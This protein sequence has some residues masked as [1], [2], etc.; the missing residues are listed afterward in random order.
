M[1]PL[2]QQ[3]VSE[4]REQ[5]QGISE[6]LLGLEKGGDIAE[7]LNE[8]FR[9]VHTL[10]GSSGLFDFPDMTRVLH[11]GEDLLTEL[12]D[13]PDLFSHDLNDQLFDCMDFVS[14]QLDDL[15]TN[16]EP[17][18]DKERADQLETALRAMLEQITAGPAEAGSEPTSAAI[19]EVNEADR[20]AE[21][22]ADANRMLDGPDQPEPEAAETAVT[23][24]PDDSPLAD[25]P[26]LV[27]HEAVSEAI[28]G[29]D[30]KL[31]HYLPEETCFFTG[32][33]P[34]FQVMQC[35]GALW[36]TVKT[37][38]PLASVDDLDPFQ[39]QLQFWAL[40][41]A[42]AEELDD[43]FRYN[44]EALSVYS[45]APEQLMAIDQHL[46]HQPVPDDVLEQLHHAYA[47]RD[48]D[49]LMTLVTHQLEASDEDCQAH[50]AL[51]WIRLVASASPDSPLLENSWQLLAELH[52]FNGHHNTEGVSI[53]HHASTNNTL[54]NAAPLNPADFSP[55]LNEVLQTQQHILGLK[56]DSPWASG[57]V[58]AAGNS[59]LNSMGSIGQHDQQAALREHLDTA[60]EHG[61]SAPMTD[62]LE[63]LLEPA[64]I[65]A[66]R[67]ETNADTSADTSSSE[68]DN[69]AEAPL[70][71]APS[72]ETPS[73]EAKA[74][75]PAQPTG[76]TAP[77]QTAS[78]STKPAPSA[79]PAAEPAR[80]ESQTTSR[81]LKVD[82][83]KIDRL[84]SLIGEMVVAKNA[85]PFL[86]Q[87]AEKLGIEDQAY[88][89]RDLS[90]EL[91]EQYGVINRISEEM[92][93]AIMQ[94]RMMPFSFIS[95]RFPRL[96]RDI[97]RRLGKDI[98]L[99][100][101]GEDTEADKNI[102]ESLAEPLIHI[103]RN[104]LDHG[105]ETPEVRTAA[106]KPASGKLS[107]RA[108]QEADRVLIEIADDGKGI[109]PDVVKRKAIEKGVIDEA[110]AE[111]M[112]DREAVNLVM[113][114]GFS[115]ADAV[116]DL[117]GRGVG[118]DAVR[119]AVDKVNGTLALDSEPGKGTRIR[120]QL[121]MSIAV[122]RVMMIETDGQLM[123]IP[124]D[125]VLETVRVDK[126][127][128]HELK[129]VKT[130]ILRNR[131]IPL[132]SLNELL[133][134][135]SL[136]ML[137]EEGEYA[138]LVIRVGAETVGLM[139][140]NFRGSADI[141]QKPLTGSVLGGVSAYSGAALVGDGS[142]L[143]VLN[144]REL[145]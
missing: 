62:W 22:L 13:H 123:G 90:R 24:L 73:T 134:L 142:V 23:P 125:Q 40:T 96:V 106:G 79:K 103:V 58:Q 69:T 76:Q 9:L 6:A 72:T 124:M 60:L 52:G 47:S 28:A 129:Q 66:T 82:Q 33:D 88:G 86:A 8:L 110:T 18:D 43:H 45:V 39:C 77:A 11:A 49:A 140:D 100:I 101:E 21:A 64:A 107:I 97:S 113:A 145:I 116:S 14:Q 78:E 131:I 139:V 15:E 10:K 56:D 36:G 67:A 95:M 20:D 111:R 63:N 42:S 2:M 17:G 138:V 143:M 41:S 85:L 74:T 119:R 34:L 121:P 136:P 99:S 108:T 105:I 114:A 32:E 141:I 65:T 19:E 46:P 48:H 81:S 27:R 130:T 3:F 70:T 26:E 87:K 144:P 102:I 61:D 91:K 115:T 112:T 122:T 94:I 37:R 92:Q 109:N 98:Q 127:N 135:D 133:N 44:P 12:R 117:S 50:V 57:R 137:N 118:M 132:K 4:S 68:A 35:P 16:G 59:L 93:D 55:E 126:A 7:G 30:V 89:S 5:L 75:E 84:M 83:E 120:I 29:S 54:G 38:Q 80:A 53:T 128:I 104:S 1:T 71:K 51:R 31:V 25:I